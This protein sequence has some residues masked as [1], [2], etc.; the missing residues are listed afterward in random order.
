[1]VV[2]SLTITSP[3]HE[4]IHRPKHNMSKPTIIFVHGAWHTPEHFE[5]LK[6]VLKSHGYTSRVAALP[7]TTIDGAPPPADIRCD[8]VAVKDVIEDVLSHGA[9]ALVVPHS[10]GGIVAMSAVKGLDEKGRQAMGKTSHVVGIAAIAAFLGREGEAL[11]TSV[12]LPAGDPKI[13]PGNDHSVHLD[14]AKAHDMLYNEM[15]RED[16]AQWVDKLRWQGRN[17]MYLLDSEYSAHK[18]IPVHFMFCANDH[19]MFPDWQR[20]VLK[21]L[22]DDG[23]D[24]RVEETD[25]DHSPYLSAI[26][27]T[28][29][30]IRRSAGEIIA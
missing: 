3:T 30:F 16:S 14:P 21:K 27:R 9:N 20:T 17:A 4:S 19:A 29:D 11:C 12:G 18:D 26:E 8:V 7:S 2:H 25:S 23:A 5:P 13:F 15:S 10:Y 22:S 24:V 1:M 28:S 6:Q